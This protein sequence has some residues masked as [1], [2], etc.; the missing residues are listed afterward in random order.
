[1]RTSCSQQTLKN[2]ASKFFSR[3]RMNVNIRK[4]SSRFCE[5]SYRKQDKYNR[6]KKDSMLIGGLESKPG[7]GTF[8]GV[9]AG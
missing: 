2:T 4:Q 3:D 5:L 9:P 1:M 7:P 8:S 6:N